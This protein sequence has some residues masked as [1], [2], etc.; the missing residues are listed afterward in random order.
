MDKL[1]ITQKEEK[2]VTMTTR[3]DKAIQEQYQ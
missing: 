2:A 3:I 1:I